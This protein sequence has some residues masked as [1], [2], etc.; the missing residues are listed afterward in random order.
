LDWVADFKSRVELE[1]SIFRILIRWGLAES[2][3]DIQ[4]IVE[5]RLEDALHCLVEGSQQLHMSAEAKTRISELLRNTYLKMRDIPRRRVCQERLHN[6]LL[7]GFAGVT[8][9]LVQASENYLEGKRA[10]PVKR[11]AA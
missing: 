2:A 4:R 11:W 1:Q 10:V 7:T 8:D 5:E 6:A 3:L 9:E